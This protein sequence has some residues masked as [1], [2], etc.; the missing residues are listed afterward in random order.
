MRMKDMAVSRKAYFG[1]DG[2]RGRV[3]SE[4]ITAKT[5]LAIGAAVGT[6]FRSSTGENCRAVIGKD[7]RLSG[8]MLEN[9]ITAGLTSVGVQVLLLGPVPTPAVGMLTRSMRA[10][11]GVM[12][13]A[14]HN[15]Y[16]DNGFKFFGSDGFKLSDDSEGRI[17]KMIGSTKTDQSVTE[18]GRAQRIDDGLARYVEYAKATFPK[19][20]GLY[21]LRIVI[22]CANGAAY[23][24]APNVLWEL[25]AEVFPVGVDPNGTNI[26][27][28]C[29]VLDTAKAAAEIYRTRADLGICL[30]GDADR[31]V[32]LDENGQPIDGDQILALFAGVLDSQDKLSDRTLVATVLSNLGLE[33]HLNERGMKLL[34]TKVGDRHV[35]AAMRE[36]NLSLGGEKSGHIVMSEYSTTGDG[37]IAALQFLAQMKITGKPCSELARIFE[38]VPQLMQ[39]VQ[40]RVGADP[41]SCPKVAKGITKAEKAMQSCGGRFLVRR[42]GTEDLIRLMAEGDDIPLMSDLMTDVADLIAAA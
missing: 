12:I 34:R 26:N 15:A 27:R 8:Y 9:A 21:G 11:V 41:L 6:Y 28:N 5:A 1:T 10:D 36:G 29:G 3:N 23:R 30:D 4:P 2:I 33:R 38:P 25:G 42:S 7:T 35:T 17:E 14:S 24:A 20:L 16:C 13:S 22:D 31:I 37:L 19:L 39:N 40:S 18:T 32:I